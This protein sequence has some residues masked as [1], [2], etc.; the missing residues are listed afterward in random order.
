MGA[1]I[2][3]EF[4]EETRSMLHQDPFIYKHKLH[5]PGRTEGAAHLAQRIKAELR[6]ADSLADGSCHDSQSG[7]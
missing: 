2:T 5:R 4:E 7:S 6:E 3:M 1:E